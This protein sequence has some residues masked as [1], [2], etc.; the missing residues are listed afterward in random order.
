MVERFNHEGLHQL[1]NCFVADEALRGRNVL[2]LTY[3][4][5]EVLKIP[6]EKVC[7]RSM[8]HYHIIDR[9]EQISPSPIQP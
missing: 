6:R 9:K 1:Q 7:Y 4:L 5:R 3:L 2:P 8:S